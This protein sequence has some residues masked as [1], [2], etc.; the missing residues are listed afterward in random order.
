MASRFCLNINDA[1][2]VLSEIIFFILVVVAFSTIT[3][4]MLVA[5]ILIGTY[6]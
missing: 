5:M 4:C 1:R 6:S 2:L 3:K